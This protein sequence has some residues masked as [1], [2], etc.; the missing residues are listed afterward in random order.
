M[1]SLKVFAEGVAKEIKEYLPPAY[2]DVEC[3]VI[4]KRENNG[5]FSVGVAFIREGENLAPIISMESFY[6]AVRNG[7]PLESIMQGLSEM[8][9]QSMNF[10]ID[11]QTM[12]AVLQ[13]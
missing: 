13:T 6:E 3:K 2:T 10:K 5:H 11:I 1:V 8:A 4:E 12:P 7:A 9:V